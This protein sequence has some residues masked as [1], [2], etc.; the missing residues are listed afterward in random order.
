M[1]LPCLLY[2]GEDSGE[3][4]IAQASVNSV[5]NATFV[6]LPNLGHVETLARQA[7]LLPH[8]TKFLAKTI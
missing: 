5:P 8:I 3:H 2:A 6:S 7:L 1:T 4:S